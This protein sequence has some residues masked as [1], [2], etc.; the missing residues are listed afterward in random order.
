MSGNMDTSETTHQEDIEITKNTQEW[1]EQDFVPLPANSPEEQ[2]E[3]SPAQEE[4]VPAEQME[5]D[6]TTEPM[7]EI[8]AEQTEEE[9]QL[10]KELKALELMELLIE[11][12][13]QVNLPEQLENARLSMHEVYPLSEGLW[14]DW[15]N[16]AKKEAGTEE[17]RAK[18]MNL[19]MQAQEDYLSMTIWKD[20]VDF[21]LENFHDKFDNATEEDTELIESTREDILVA[22][23]ATQFHIK[24]SQEI[25][26]P[27]VEFEIEILNKFKK[28]EQQQRVKQ[29]FLSRLAVLHIDY[30][31]TFDSFSTF[32]STWDNSKYEETMKEANKI[33]SHTKSAAEER[34][35]F[36][37]NIVSSGYTLDA[38]YQYIENEKISKFMTSV[39]NV[40]CLYERA[41]VYYCT[42]PTLWDDYILYLI[43]KGRVASL[44]NT[45]IIRAIRN[46]PWSGTLYAHKARLL[47]SEKATEDQMN[48]QLIGKKA[49][50]AD[51]V[52]RMEL[53]FME[54]LEYLT[55]AFPDSGDP[56]YR[57]EKCYASISKKRLYDADRARQL[58]ETIV[59]KH[60]RDTEAWISYITFERDEGDYQACE[61]LFKKAM[62]KNVDNPVRLIE[63]WNAF[64]REF[65]TIETYEKAA[66]IIN[67]KVKGFSRQWQSSL[68]EQEKV[69]EEKEKE[70]QDILKRKKGLHRMEQKKKQKERKAANPRE[71]KKPFKPSDD[72]FK[73]PFKPSDDSF[74]KPHETPRTKKEDKKPVDYKKPVA[75]VKPDQES[76]QSQMSSEPKEAE[77]AEKSQETTESGDNTPNTKD[78]NNAHMEE[79][80]TH[81]KE[82]EEAEE[83]EGLGSTLKRKASATDFEEEQAKKHKANDIEE[84]PSSSK[85]KAAFNPR[86]RATRGHRG[87]RGK[88]VVPSARSD[89]Q[90]VAEPAKSAVADTTS[91]SNDDF[92]NMLLGKK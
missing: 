77:E 73:K 64:E 59:K 70:R 5:E 46:C 90:Q 45:V 71:F 84:A 21:I 30:Q 11:T 78:I 83:E 22:V 54:S 12:L 68:A 23:R 15:I 39:N 57:I 26:K 25:W 2:R 51:D 28:P 43:E 1:V 72:S 50:D 48:G 92:R 6:V 55:E 14:L 69:N 24:Q 10:A 35:L 91:K 47:E 31:D 79:D 13:K 7:E 87:G 82:G 81:V 20:Y 40:R 16:D 62:E 86:P 53:V 65:G 38:F 32:T 74:K 4:N 76:S 36:E 34:D 52:V 42:D 3:D 63:A 17:G 49:T 8:P 9:K 66:I 56:Y 61:T 41:I 58:W 67:R 18:L 37:I 80:K 88:I 89:T 29:L 60:G 85:P 33:Y 75:F 27:F 19:Y 44:L